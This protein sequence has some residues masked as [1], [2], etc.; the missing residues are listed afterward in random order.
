VAVGK[1]HGQLDGAAGRHVGGRASRVPL[2]PHVVALGGPDR[3]SEAPS[4]GPYSVPSDS[5]GSTADARRAG[6]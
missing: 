3:L 6:T 2:R 4:S 1:R 5:I